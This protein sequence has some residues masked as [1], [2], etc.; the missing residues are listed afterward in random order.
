MYYKLN[1]IIFYIFCLLLISCAGKSNVDSAS[2]N[3][4]PP[5]EEKVPSK[6]IT[7]DDRREFDMITKIFSEES[8]VKTFTEYKEIA[9]PALE[10]YISESSNKKAAFNLYIQNA[11]IIPEYAF[12]VVKSDTKTTASYRLDH[13]TLQPLFDQIESYV[14]TLERF[15][16]DFQSL[17][18]PTLDTYKSDFDDYLQSKKNTN[19]NDYWT[20]QC[21]KSVLREGVK[22]SSESITIVEDESNTNGAEINWT[23]NIH[24]SL[25]GSN[26]ETEFYSILDYLNNLLPISQKT[27][28][29]INLYAWKGD[30]DNENDNQFGMNLSSSISKKGATLDFIL[31]I[32]SYELDNNHDHQYSVIAH[33]YFHTYQLYQYPHEYYPIKWL[34]EGSAAVFESLFIQSEYK[35]NYF[36]NQ[37][38]LNT[39]Y[40]AS[41]H[42]QE[43]YNEP[44]Q[45]YCN[46][47]FFILVLSKKIQSESGISE[48]EALTKI[49]KTFMEDP[50]NNLPWEGHFFDVFGFTVQEFYQH[51][52][53]Y[54][55]LNNFA[56][57]ILELGQ[58][59]IVFELLLSDLYLSP[60]SQ[61]DLIT[62]ESSQGEPTKLNITYAQLFFELKNNANPEL[63]YLFKSDS[64]SLLPSKNLDLEAIFE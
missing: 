2:L 28:H 13:L 54:S 20:L 36:S 1:I 32:S 57:S 41:P 37:D 56:H 26:W 62:L 42:L 33:E 22:S 15:E 25:N 9:V 48:Q 53:F 34:M 7:P 12:A 58:D 40:L 14:A 30:E 38:C 47:V 51:L 44:D 27:F 46:S 59:K 19:M 35:E 8:N 61:D 29:S 31:E 6:N 17:Y 3:S 52:G 5:I 10:L 4:T 23:I 45:N 64:F 21:I 60:S 55:E 49:L 11:H 24:D 39:D 16:K 18:S 63:G 43:N 50:S